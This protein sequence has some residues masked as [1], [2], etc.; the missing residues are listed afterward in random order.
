MHPLILLTIALSTGVFVLDLATP[1]GV[2]TEMLY[3][4]VVLVAARSPQW[5]VGVYAAAMATALT[6]LGFHMSP[7][8][9]PLWLDLSNRALAIFAIWVTTILLLINKKAESTLREM[10]NRFEAQQR[11][12]AAQLERLL[13]SLTEEMAR[14]S[15]AEAAQRE[16]E[17]QYHTR[18]RKFEKEL[19]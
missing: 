7:P 15:H 19:S 14:R 18:L 6:A 3:L 10:N 16:V 11:D 2:A 5:P 9:A 13:H 4:L 17:A 12:H 8:G 1:L